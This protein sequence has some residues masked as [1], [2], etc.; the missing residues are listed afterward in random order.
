[1]KEPAIF[2]EK[3][4]VVAVDAHNLVLRGVRTGELVTITNADP[5]TPFTQKDY[6]PGKLIAITDPAKGVGPG[7]EA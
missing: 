2:T 5:S 6:P 3:F 1:M 7:T 4:R